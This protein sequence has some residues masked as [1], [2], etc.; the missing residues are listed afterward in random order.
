MS[1]DLIQNNIGS[2]KREIVS[3]CNR[4]GRNPKDIKIIAASKYADSLQIKKASDAGIF[5]FGENRAEELIKKFEIIGN[6]VIW[7]FIGH[8]QGRKVR[9]VVPIVEIIH[10]VDKINTLEKINEIA[11]QNNKIQKILIELNISNEQSKYGMKKE[12]LIAFI[13]N[14]REFKHIKIIGLMT[15]APLTDDESIIRQVFKG[16]RDL[17]A[18]IN[19]TFNGIDLRELSMGMS[20]DYGIAIEEGSTMLRIGS[21]IFL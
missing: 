6:S 17:M 4:S 9:L 14:S 3:T 2:L 12:E 19:K 21:S 5:D 7:H 16:L 18:D 20:N 10:S 11:F 13:K 1:T 15:M 8:L